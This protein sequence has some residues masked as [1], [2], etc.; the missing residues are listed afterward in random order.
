VE[1]PVE[2]PPLAWE[3]EVEAPPVLLAVAPEVVACCPGRQAGRP[4]QKRVTIEA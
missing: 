4:M 2:A 1:A 3:V